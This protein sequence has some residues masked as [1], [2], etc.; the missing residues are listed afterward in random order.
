[1]NQG[2]H[3]V[4]L[5][6]WFLGDVAEVS[7]VTKTLGRQVEVETLALS[8]VKFTNGAQGVIEAT[9]LA[10][11]E[12]PCYVELIGSRGTLAFTGEKLLHMELIDPTPEEVS[13]RDA[14]LAQRRQLEA[15]QA[16][17]KKKVT[18]GTAVPSLDMGHA[19]VIEDFVEAVRTRREPWVPG[20]EARRSVDLI[21]AIYE[22]GRQDGK[23]VRLSG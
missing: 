14:L 10:Y 11:P 16:A 23:P 21:C 8:L 18:P 12:F 9:T 13:V 6:A 3:T 7:A 5:F 22:S 19:P 2:I 1:M 15:A 20:K 4:D 17:E